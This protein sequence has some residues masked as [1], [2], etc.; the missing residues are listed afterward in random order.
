MLPAMTS[1]PRIAIVG[2]GRLGTAVAIQLKRAGY[3]ISELVS[4]SAHFSGAQKSLAKRVRAHLVSPRKADL[5]AELVWFCVPDRKISAAAQDLLRAVEWKGRVAFHSSGALSSEELRNLRK[6][7]AK[8]ASVHPM[9]TFV[10]GTVSPLQSVPFALEGDA[11]AIKLAARIVADLGGFSFKISA[12]NK[13]AYHA[14]GAFASPLVIALLATA[15][16]VA[17]AAG[18]Q[19]TEARKHMLPILRQTIENYGRFGPDGAFSGPLVRGDAEVVRKH[20]GVLR[21]VPGAAEVYLAL[22]RS[23]L[24]HIPVQERANLKRILKK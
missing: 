9:M 22:A 23:A 16:Q 13:A 19:T 2:T 20:L 15:E 7:G 24:R 1:R 14:W 5:P 6:R 4:H 18:I 3:S 12:R 17:R 11:A 8:V 10:H 21:K